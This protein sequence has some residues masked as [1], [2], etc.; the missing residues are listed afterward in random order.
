M[1]WHG[2]MRMRVGCG[3]WLLVLSWWG[4]GRPLRTRPRDAPGVPWA[5]CGTG[6]GAGIATGPPPRLTPPPAAQQHWAFPHTHYRCVGTGFSFFV[7]CR[8]GARVLCVG[9]Q[10]RGRLY[11]RAGGTTGT[12]SVLKPLG[13]MS[14]IYMY[15]HT[16]FHS[17]DVR[18]RSMPRGFTDSRRLPLVVA[19][20]LRF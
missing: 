1:S 6:V 2:C 19:R 3:T 8:I 15:M 7:L 17:G 10:R 5:S 11:C 16:F 18:T 14:H 13:R 4:G 12:L 20:T 9:E